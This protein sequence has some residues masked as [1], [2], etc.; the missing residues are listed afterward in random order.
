MRHDDSYL[1]DM[2]QA[3][4]KAAVF[5]ADLTYPQ[6]RDSDL[7]QNAIV[8]VLEIVGEAASRITTDT[9]CAYPQIPWRQII[10]LR[11]RVVHGYF[12][13]DLKLIWHIVHQ[14]VPILIDQ[15]QDLLPPDAG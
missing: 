2:L 8:K 12:D 6:F 7:H 14:D 3:A 11:N 1:I 10:G 5:A 15:L 4:R 9:H 13:V